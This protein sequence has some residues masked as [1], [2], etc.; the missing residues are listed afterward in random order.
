M[1]RA[2]GSCR[3]SAWLLVAAMRHFGLA[4]RFVSGY[5]VQL[6]A[7]DRVAGRAVRSHPGLHRPAR[8]GRGVHPGRRL[9]RARSDLGAVRRRGTHPAGGDPAPGERGPDRGSHRSDPGDVRLRQH[10]HAG[11]RGS[12]GHQAVHARRRSRTCTSRPAGR[13]PS[14][15][16][17]HRADDGR[18]ADLRVGRR[19]DLGRVDRRRRRPAQARAGQPAGRR[20]RRAVRHRRSGPAQPGQVVSG[21]AAAALADRAASGGPTAS[22]SGRTRRCCADPFD[23]SR[24]LDDA[25]ARARAYARG[26]RRRVRATREPVPAVLRGPAVGPVRGAARPEGPRTDEPEAGRSWSAALDAAQPPPPGR[27]R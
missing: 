5:L 2:I 17:R 11:A 4:A 19:H 24:A 16:C 18:R 10:R 15:R 13:R 14:G 25:D 1:T 3:D 20:A 9:G 12:A 26:D 6:A 22:R 23:P 27:S 7:D 21:R 8:L